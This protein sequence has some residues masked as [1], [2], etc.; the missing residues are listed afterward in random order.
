MTE[1]KVGLEHIDAPWRM[2]YITQTTQ[3]QSD[4][5]IFCAKP[6]ESESCD[7]ANYL[8]HRGKHC[9]IIMNAFPYNGG[10]SMVIPFRHISKLSE[11]TAEEQLEMMQLSTLLANAM[12]KTMCPDGFNLGMN[13]GRAGG[14]GIAEHIHLHVVPRWVGDTNFMTT[15]GN[16]RVLPEA[17]VQTWEKL[18][19][20]I[21]VLLAEENS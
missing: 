4:D 15:I 20:A 13:I 19:D 11:L 3:P 17:I 8:L 18:K 2:E 16:S 12:T 10:H 5:C 21:A 1:E 6:C 9:F 14:A 7:R